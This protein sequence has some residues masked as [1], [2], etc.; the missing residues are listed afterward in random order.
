MRTWYLSR[1]EEFSHNE[2]S[3]FIENGNF[4]IVFSKIMPKFWKFSY[5]KLKHKTCT[6][7]KLFLYLGCLVDM[8]MDWPNIIRP[9]SFL[10]R[11]IKGIS[12]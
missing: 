12:G 5:V 4:S 6:V 9:S 8:N 7:Q 11:T 2:G 1:P 3:K 10:G